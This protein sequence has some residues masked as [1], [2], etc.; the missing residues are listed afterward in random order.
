M[1][2]LLL[3]VLMSFSFLF[4]QEI[5]TIIAVK[6]NVYV[7]DASDL[8]YIKAK[9]GMKVQGDARVRIG[10]NSYLAVY[11]HNKAVEEKRPGTYIISSLFQRKHDT[12]S[13]QSRYTGYVL[14]QALAS[15]S[16][17]ASGRTLGAV[18]RSTLAPVPMMKPQS[19]FFADSVIL[20]WQSVA[21]AEGYDVRIYDNN[22]NVIQTI[23]TNHE[24]ILFDMSQLS[25]DTTS[26]FY[27]DV[28]TS[29]YPALRS[30]KVCF[31]LIGKHTAESLRYQEKQIIGN[32]E[33]SAIL[34][35]A[36]AKFYDEHGMYGYALLRSLRCEE[37]TGGAEWCECLDK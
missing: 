29:K 27:F 16:G 37:I 12:N 31:K 25:K 28:A 35:A 18:T 15:S 4:A 17:R 20:F 30:Q 7:S 2:N 36:L 21:G 26:C 6:G 3:L 10:D 11:A 34:N 19:L 8:S 32:Q 33:D 1:K 22:G 14:N 9:T 13:F 24:S 5:Y 23:Q